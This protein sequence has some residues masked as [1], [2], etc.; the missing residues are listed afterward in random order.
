MKYTTKSNVFHKG[1]KMNYS[2][3]KN[4]QSYYI[5]VE[6]HLFKS[7]KTFIEFLSSVAIDDEMLQEFNV[8]NYEMIQFIQDIYSSNTN[9][10][11]KNEM[12]KM[13]NRNGY[14]VMIY[15]LT[16]QQNYRAHEVTAKKALSKNTLLNGA[17][18]FEVLGGV[19]EN[20]SPI[21][22]NRVY[23]LLGE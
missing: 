7:N 18:Y 4:L 21:N 3:F 16:P 20:Y 15:N 5:E 8:S 11:N 14:S 22:N 6:K 10:V 23:L 12:I 17:C 19:F 2:T 1:Y 9:K 13:I